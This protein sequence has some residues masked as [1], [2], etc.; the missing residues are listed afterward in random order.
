MSVEAAIQ[1]MEASGAVVVELPGGRR[2]I[3]GEVPD[4]VIECARDQRESFLAAW[5]TAV[6][7][8][9]LRQ[10]P[11]GLPFRKAPPRT[12]ADVRRRLR[13]YSET[14]GPEIARWIL[15]RAQAYMERG[16]FS[17]GDA[18]IC[19][20]VDLLAWQMSKHNNPVEVLMGLEVP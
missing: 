7:N 20:R 14:Q 3:K 9:Y 2:S 10:P 18:Q 6:R 4:W 17:D 16:G 8:R 5:D 19:A 12:R 15:D 13:E 11:A 1:E